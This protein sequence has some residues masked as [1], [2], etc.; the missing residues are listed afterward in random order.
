MSKIIQTTNPSPSPKFKSF[1][2][3]TNI[4]FRLKNDISCNLNLKAFQTTGRGG[5]GHSFSESLHSW[6]RKGRW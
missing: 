1:I 3:E 6:N 2:H 4:N 5:K